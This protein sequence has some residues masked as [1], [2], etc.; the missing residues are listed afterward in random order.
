MYTIV[1][2][3]N[4]SLSITFPNLTVTISL[5]QDLFIGAD[6]REFLLARGSYTCHHNHLA[7]KYGDLFIGADLG[8]FLLARGSYY[9]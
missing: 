1:P 8:E 2:A 5:Y 9:R 4:H 7:M 3:L 6:L